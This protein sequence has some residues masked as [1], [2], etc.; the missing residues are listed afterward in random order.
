MIWRGTLYYVI[1]LL[2]TNCPCRHLDHLLATT[3]SD[4]G[5]HFYFLC[6]NLNVEINSSGFF[7][8]RQNTAWGQYGETRND[9]SMKVDLDGSSPFVTSLAVLCA[10]SPL[11]SVTVS[12]ITCTCR[13]FTIGYSQITFMEFLMDSQ[14]SL[15]KWRAWMRGFCSRGLA[16]AHDAAAGL[17]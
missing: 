8:S 15:V 13:T 4:V 7:L 2:L 3:H 11:L 10:S 1:N 5:A 17:Y 9:A 6:L 14:A 12:F 16:G